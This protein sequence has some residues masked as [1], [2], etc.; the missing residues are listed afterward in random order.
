MESPIHE[1][2]KGKSKNIFFQLR[3]NVTKIKFIP[4]HSNNE[5]KW[6]YK[7]KSG[8]EFT[9]NY[10]IQA[11]PKQRNKNIFIWKF[12]SIFFSAFALALLAH[13]VYSAKI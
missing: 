6:K 10:K 5:V 1:E 7:K 3:Y 2:K 8:K 13:I 9:Y 4:A 11:M 12:T